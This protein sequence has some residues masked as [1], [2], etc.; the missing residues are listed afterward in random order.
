V[1]V[2]NVLLRSIC[3]EK[4]YCVG[5]QTG[6][7]IPSGKEAVSI[8]EGNIYK[9]LQAHLGSYQFEGSYTSTHEDKD[10]QA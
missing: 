5:E 1:P 10:N 7:F 3:A 9:G 6:K 4:G 8:K 2:E